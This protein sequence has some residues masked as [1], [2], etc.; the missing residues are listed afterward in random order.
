MRFL[1]TNPTKDPEQ[2]V[3]K[4]TRLG[5][6]T[7]VGDIVNTVVTTTRWLLGSA[8]LAAVGNWSGRCTASPRACARA[9]HEA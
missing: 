4:L 9:E 1:S 2:D 6:P 3:D 7:R 5:L 8:I